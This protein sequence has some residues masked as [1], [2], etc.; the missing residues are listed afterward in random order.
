M[1]L[2]FSSCDRCIQCGWCRRT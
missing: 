2:M 1:K